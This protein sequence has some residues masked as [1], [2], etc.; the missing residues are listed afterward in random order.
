MLW[1]RAPGPNAAIG[2]KLDQTRAKMITDL[3]RQQVACEGLCILEGNMHNQTMQST[4]FE[5]L[6]SDGILQR[7]LVRWC[8]LGI[9]HPQSGRPPSICTQW[10]TNMPVLPE[11]D[12]RCQCGSN[13]H[14]HLKDAK[15]AI[16]YQHVGKTEDH[17]Y[18]VM[19]H[20]L[21][22][23]LAAISATTYLVKTGLQIRP[24][25]RGKLISTLERT[26]NAIQLVDTD[27]NLRQHMIPLYQ[28]HIQA[29][30]QQHSLST[31]KLDYATNYNHLC[32]T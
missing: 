19:Q 5:N 18:Q 17:M 2:S 3:V 9:T 27:Y 25:L 6:V 32:Q 21:L 23:Q 29:L 22:H 12:G 11:S 30:L 24:E 14:N 16:Q 15:H 20:R 7:N 1:I 4:W 8:N 31:T 13:Q 28:T 26:L 10:W